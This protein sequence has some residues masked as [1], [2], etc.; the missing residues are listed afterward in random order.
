[1][2]KGKKTNLSVRYSISS[3]NIDKKELKHFILKITHL[4]ILLHFSL[5]S[6]VHSEAYLDIPRKNVSKKKKIVP[7]HP[8][9]FRL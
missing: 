4:F 6:F 3:F 5:V 8:N 1:M 9:G 7:T 2:F